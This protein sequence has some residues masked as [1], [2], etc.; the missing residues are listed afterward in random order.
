MRN[1]L[2]ATKSDENASS[3]NNTILET[4][5]IFHFIYRDV[6]QKNWIFTSEN[7][8]C[9]REIEEGFRD[10]KAKIDIL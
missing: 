2:P 8:H 4:S 1:G 5:V 3:K 6:F 10:E 9:Q 7:C